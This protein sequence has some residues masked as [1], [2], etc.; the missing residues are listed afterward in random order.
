MWALAPCLL[1]LADGGLAC[2]HAGALEISTARRP[3]ISKSLPSSHRPPGQWP[4]AQRGA[5]ESEFAWLRVR[6]LG[7]LP[8]SGHAQPRR[9]QASP[10]EFP[11]GLRADGQMEEL[12]DAESPSISMQTHT[13]WMSPPPSSSPSQLLPSLE[14]PAQFGAVERLESKWTDLPSKSSSVS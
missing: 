10:T 6:R 8:S 12:Q 2:S 14:L 5:L 13:N 9:P 3:Q 4:R 11:R 1:G 7:P